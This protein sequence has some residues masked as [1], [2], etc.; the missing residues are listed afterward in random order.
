MGM[1][2]RFPE[3]KGNIMTALKSSLKWWKQGKCLSGILRSNG[4]AAFADMLMKVL[5]LPNGVLTVS[6]RGSITNQPTWMFRGEYG[7]IHMQ[8]L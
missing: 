4:N 7:K 6:T 2:G 1:P 8:C 5:S 3:L